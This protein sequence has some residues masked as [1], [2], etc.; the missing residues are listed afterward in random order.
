LTS[1]RIY[2]GEHY[3]K[4]PFYSFDRHCLQL[5]RPMPDEADAQCQPWFWGMAHRQSAAPISGDIILVEF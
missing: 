3:R 5:V 2:C 1:G 4:L